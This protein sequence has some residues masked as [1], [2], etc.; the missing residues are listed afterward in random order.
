M[1]LFRVKAEAT[2]SETVSLWC[3]LYHL[4]YGEIWEMRKCILQNKNDKENEEGQLQ[5]FV[6]RKML[7]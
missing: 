5:D 6:E 3:I 4:L 2:E 7:T 1:P